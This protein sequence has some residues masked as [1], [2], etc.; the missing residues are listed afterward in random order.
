MSD[1]KPTINES[2]SPEQTFYKAYKELCD[3]HNFEVIA[4]PS[5]RARDDGTFSTVLTY[6]V[7]SLGN[8]K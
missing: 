3:K 2:L 8:S 1:K 4:H 7:R 6:G 5:F